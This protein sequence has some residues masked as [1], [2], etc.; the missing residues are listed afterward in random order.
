[1]KST[2]R[3]GKLAACAF[4]LLKSGQIM[5]P[6]LKAYDPDLHNV[7]VDSISDL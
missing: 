1:M 4:L 6:L 5:F 7:V 3:Y 2:L